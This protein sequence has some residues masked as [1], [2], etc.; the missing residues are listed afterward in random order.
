MLKATEKRKCTQQCHNE[1]YV[2]KWHW[3]RILI[4]YKPRRYELKIH[5]E[6]KKK[7]KKKKDF[8]HNVSHFHDVRM[9][10]VRL[11]AGDLEL[12]FPCGWHDIYS[13]WKTKARINLWIRA[14]RSDYL[15]FV[16]VCHHDFVCLI[17]TCIP[18]WIFMGLLIR[19][20]TTKHD[21]RKSHFQYN[22][23]VKIQKM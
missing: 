12:L 8:H 13:S 3:N 16:R 7:K 5:K 15:L 19:H 23:Y 17:A 20:R 11:C 22:I 6:K 14:V 2:H 10:R 21:S 18:T 1:F 4:L 9:I